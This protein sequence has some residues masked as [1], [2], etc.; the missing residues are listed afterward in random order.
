MSKQRI[1]S[2]AFY[3]QQARRIGMSLIIYTPSNGDVFRDV[4]NSM[5]LLI[6]SPTFTSAIDIVTGLS[7]LAAA[8]MYIKTSQI[9]ALAQWV[10]NSF[11]IL[12]VLVGITMQVNIVDMSNDRATYTVN[13][14]PIGVALPAFVVSSI[15]QAITSAF[16][17]FFHMPA[18]LDYNKTG[19]VFG[20]R[21]WV[22]GTQAN[23]NRNSDLAK[24]LNSYISQC[25]F[26]SKMLV[27][28]KLSPQELKDAPDL[29]KTLFDKPSV[30]YHV[31]MSDGQNINCKNAAEII[32]PK[33]KEAH[34][35]E[36][37]ILARLLSKSTQDTDNGLKAAHEYYSQM[38]KNSADI[39]TQNIMINAVRDA[40]RNAFAL[41]GDIGQL[42]NYTN[43]STQ[44]KMR[45]AEAND[46]WLSDYQLPLIMSSLWIMSIC[47]FPIIVLISFFPQCSRVYPL[48]VYSLVYLWSWPPLFTII[49]F[50]VSSAAS[51]KINLFA[52]QVGGITLSNVD[53]VKMIHSDFA[54]KAGRLASLVPIIAF[55]IV[56]S[57]SYV[58]NIAAQS[59]GGTAQSLSAG[60]AQ[61]VA[62]GNISMAQYSGWNTN[63]DTENAHKHDTNVTEMHGQ[64]SIQS[65][66]GVIEHS[67]AYGEKSYSL[68]NSMTNSAVS[69]T[70]SQ[71]YQTSLT[72]AEEK[73][74][75]EMDGYR[76]A[77]DT[78]LAQASN[79]ST[80]YT[81]NQGHDEKLG[82]GNS[83]TESVSAQ[84]ALSR[85]VHKAE[86][87]SEKTGITYD[88][89]FTGLMR[90]GMGA[91]GGIKTDNGVF[92]KLA[93][94]SFGA[95]GDVNISAGGEQSQSDT[96]R[97]NTGN[98]YV[99]SAREAND[100][101]AD[102][103]TVQ[104]Y[105]KNHHFDQNNTD[106]ENLTI[107]TGTDLRNAMVASDGYNASLMKSERISDVK[108]YLQTG[109]SSVLSNFNQLAFDYGVDK[110]GQKHMKYLEENHRNPQAF[111]E[112]AAIKQEF[113]TY[114]V[115]D[116][117][118]RGIPAFSS[119]PTAAFNN[120]ESTINSNYDALK[121]V[122]NTQKEQLQQR[123]Q[124]NHLGVNQQQKSNLIKESNTQIQK[125]NDF[126][127][128]GAQEM[129]QNFK[130][131][132][133]QGL[134]R[135]EQGK[136][137]ATN[138]PVAS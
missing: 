126:I 121:N 34:K 19:M 67:N 70:G 90:A 20:S 93:K 138:I 23:L 107:Q 11:L 100:I 17:A 78:S 133:Q 131:D 81:E 79:H 118:E 16:G 56:K 135:I 129:V 15:G 1:V 123:A 60:E 61:A 134:D 41:N 48:Y 8:I 87:I 63:Y 98:D 9:T 105:A 3:W 69:V 6:G 28:K 4:L 33:I 49:H 7:V 86:D 39:L 88:E 12:F 130:Q 95:H 47:M 5:A 128:K 112:L 82:H 74:L 13:N 30:V 102:I 52:Q 103:N 44:Q 31:M 127:G 54:L 29:F 51:T 59:F 122:H 119:N 62:H 10:V 91:S 92:G 89:A 116:L 18:D 46:F 108:N 80:Q 110:V 71:G 26:K 53:T 76:S 109:G 136:D 117:I 24:D 35:P 124:D 50:L 113:M 65:S 27:Q 137:K 97:H 94:W 84:E 25:V 72:H 73:S 43:S 64:T 14:V 22:G 40:E 36:L 57:L 75:Q 77:I 68:G 125:S 83:S 111:N 42:M 106:A 66:T 101:K 104:A 114:K 21:I 96:A 45:I 99:I 37:E 55:G 115:N 2:W 32:Q 120:A 132:K 85:L 38:S 58:M